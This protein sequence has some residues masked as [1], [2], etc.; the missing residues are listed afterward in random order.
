MDT[1]EPGAKKTAVFGGFAAGV[2]QVK[3]VQESIR[4]MPE[5][6]MMDDDNY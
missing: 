2:K 6:R 5:V 3:A 4:D 1:D